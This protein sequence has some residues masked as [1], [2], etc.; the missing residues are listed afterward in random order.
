[1]IVTGQGWAGLSRLQ[2]DGQPGDDVIAMTSSGAVAGG[3]GLGDRADGRE[4]VV[5]VVLRPERGQ[6]G[7]RSALSHWAVSPLGRGPLGRVVG[8]RT[9]VISMKGYAILMPY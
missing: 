9:W 4:L 7:A 5:G 8:P 6:C 3:G 2:P 1:M